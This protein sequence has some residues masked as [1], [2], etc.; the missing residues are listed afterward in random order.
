MFDDDELTRGKKCILRARDKN[1][2]L[3]HLT[4]KDKQWHQ[5]GKGLNTVA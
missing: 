1:I 5:R 4:G 3:R 2:K